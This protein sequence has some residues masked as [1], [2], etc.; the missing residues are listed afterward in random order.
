MPSTNRPQRLYDVTTSMLLVWGTRDKVVPRGMYRCLPKG[1]QR[2][3][4]SDDRKRGASTGGS[5]A[6][7][8]F[9]GL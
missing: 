1:Y 9:R 7:M 5:S 8:S 3:E 6:S 2:C 4:G